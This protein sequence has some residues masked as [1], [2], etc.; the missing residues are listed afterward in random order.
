MGAGNQA[1]AEKNILNA[2][3]QIGDWQAAQDIH[4][5]QV[6]EQNSQLQTASVFGAQRAALGANGVQLGSGSAL[7]A[8]TTTSYM[9]MR[10]ALQIKDNAAMSAWSATTGAN[11]DR[12]SAASISPSMAIV[13]SLLGSASQVGRQ[14]MSYGSGAPSAPATG[15]S[16][17]QTGYNP[18]QSYYG[19][20]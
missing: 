14:W 4:V 3:A 12:S 15:M 18:L 19:S 20:H 13:G 7:D 5:G 8:L 16:F 9:G 2:K 11:L 17:Q 1:A 10:N 6:Q